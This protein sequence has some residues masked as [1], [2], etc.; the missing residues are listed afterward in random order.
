MPSKSTIVTYLLLSIYS[1][2][3]VLA[4][5][6]GSKEGRKLATDITGPCTKDA[7]INAGI[8]AATLASE[9]GSDADIET[10]CKEAYIDKEEM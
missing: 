3:N 8:S 10:A 5:I 6:R 9:I 7:L 2:E 4:N 1:N